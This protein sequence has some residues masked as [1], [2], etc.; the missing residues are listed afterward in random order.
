MA[1]IRYLCASFHHKTIRHHGSSPVPLDTLI[2]LR[3]PLLTTRSGV[4]TDVI[5]VCGRLRIFSERYEPAS[6]VIFGILFC[7]DSRVQ[8]RASGNPVLCISILTRQ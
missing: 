5:Y 1:N 7:I 4:F 2:F 6:G 3:Y 8:K